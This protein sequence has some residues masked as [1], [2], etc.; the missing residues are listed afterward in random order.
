MEQKRGNSMAEETKELLS[1]EPERLG[2]ATFLDEEAKEVVQARRTC[3]E[4]C[5]TSNLLCVIIFSLS[6][7]FISPPRVLS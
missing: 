6:S 2:H 5:L 4:I 7:F 1:C 3:I